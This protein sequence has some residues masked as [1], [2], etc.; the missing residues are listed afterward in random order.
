MR[1]FFPR[2]RDMR[3]R[4][5]LDAQRKGVR[6]GRHAIFR[7]DPIVILENSPPTRPM[8]RCRIV[9]GIRKIEGRIADTQKGRVLPASTRPPLKHD[10][11]PE[12]GS[13]QGE[14]G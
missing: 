11:R 13:Q 3:I 2:E 14:A 6:I 4:G 12:G 9:E 10:L 8:R 5:Q 1:C 7:I